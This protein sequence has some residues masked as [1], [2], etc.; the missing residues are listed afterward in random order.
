MLAGSMLN[1][2]KCYIDCR[3]MP[4]QDAVYFG[5]GG[6]LRSGFGKQVL[7]PQPTAPNVGFGSSAR[8]ASQHIYASAEHDRA[9]VKS[10]GGNQSQGAIYQMPVS[11]NSSSNAGVFFAMDV[12]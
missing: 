6:E 9:K 12:P 4:L 8:A 2:C 1:G 7:A 11:S 3:N 5:H 10:A